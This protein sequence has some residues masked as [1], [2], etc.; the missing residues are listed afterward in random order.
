MR[1]FK[2][3]TKIIR[4][5]TNTPMIGQNVYFNLSLECNLTLILVFFSTFIAKL[6]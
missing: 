6:F 1:V 5:Y 3:I 4:T 2:L